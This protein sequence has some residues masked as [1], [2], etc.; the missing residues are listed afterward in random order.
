M[1][2][3]LNQSNTRFA[4]SSQ[5]WGVPQLVGARCLIAAVCMRD[6]AALRYWVPSSPMPRTTLQQPDYGQPS[7]PYQAV[8]G[9]RLDRMLTTGR[10]EPA[11]RQPH[12]R[13]GVAIQVDHE[14]HT[15]DDGRA[16]AF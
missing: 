2:S 4:L 10:A 14:D 12:R 3:R 15:A 7:T 5:C 11:R 1:T 9:E 16:V 6:V 13:N 8:F